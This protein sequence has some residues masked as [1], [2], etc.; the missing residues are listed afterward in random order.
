MSRRKKQARPQ[1]SKYRLQ[2]ESAWAHR[3]CHIINFERIFVQPIQPAKLS[4]IKCYI[5]LYTTAKPH[6]KYGNNLKRQTHTMGCE[7]ITSLSNQIYDKSFYYE[8]MIS[9]RNTKHTGAC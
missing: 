5:A 2:I 1:I 3:L 7:H 8:W 6:N 9:V 4:G